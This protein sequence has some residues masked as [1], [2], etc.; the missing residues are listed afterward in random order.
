MTRFYRIKRTASIF[1]W[2][3]ITAAAGAVSCQGA[4]EEAEGG[5]SCAEVGTHMGGVCN[6]TDG[7]NLELRCELLGMSAST[8]ECLLAVSECHAT[9]CGV[10]IT[11]AVCGEDA[12]CPG[13]LVCHPT[14]Q[15]CT[16][17][18]TDDDCAAPNHCPDGFCIAECVTDDDCSSSSVCRENLCIQE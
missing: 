7:R 11:I 15:V 14:R 1:G 3:L 4:D 13:E 2:L 5:P 9:N 16:E 12:E 6:R 10:D 17:C 18:V 8:R